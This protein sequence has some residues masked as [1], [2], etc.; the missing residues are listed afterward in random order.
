MLLIRLLNVLYFIQNPWSGGDNLRDKMKKF[1]VNYA[2]QKR[3]LDTN[4]YYF[5]QNAL[6]ENTLNLL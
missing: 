2:I 6:K 5:L 1:A 4:K 3:I